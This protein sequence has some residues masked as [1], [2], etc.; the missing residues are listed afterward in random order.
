MVMGSEGAQYQERLCWRG[1]SSN[2]LDSTGL[3]NFEDRGLTV[4]RAVRQ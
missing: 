1:P 2:L 4:T 3:D